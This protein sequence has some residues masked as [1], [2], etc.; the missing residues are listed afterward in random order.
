MLSDKLLLHLGCSLMLA[1]CYSPSLHAVSP[2][3]TDDAD[4][5][6]SGQL[7]LNPIW[8]FTR[9]GSLRLHVLPVN[10]VLGLTSRGELGATFGYQWRDGS[11]AVD[12]DGITDLTFSTKWRW[13]QSKDEKLRL[14]TRFDL[15][16]PTAAEDRGLG[17]GKVDGAAVLIAT[18]TLG[19]TSIDWN[20]GYAWSDLSGT[21]L[22]DDTW[23]IAQAVRHELN[24]AWTVVGE[25]FAILPHSD[26]GGS[27]NFSLQGGAQL[28]LRENLVISA[29]IGS[30]AGRNSPDL[31]SRLGI[32]CVF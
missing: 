23:F 12:A 2:L 19:S 1:L 30:A 22:R 25:M 15:T 26:R 17:T 7:Q 4:T 20:L 24:K 9:T 10:P 11:N 27:A 21:D 3:V 29:L 31:V 16:L 28:S 6:E 14:S 18:R 8:Q 13:W 5:V 32:S